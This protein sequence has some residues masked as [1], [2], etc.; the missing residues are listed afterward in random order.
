MKIKMVSIDEDVEQILRNAKLEGNNLTLQG[1][2]TPQMYKKVMKVLEL[3]GF[4]WS[5]KAKCHIGE[6]DSAEKFSE[7]LGTGK[8]V[9][10]K[11][12]YQFFETP[13]DVAAKLA[14]YACIGAGDRVLE[15]SAGKGALIRAIQNEYPKLGHIFACELN[16][17]MA[18]DLASL[19]AASRI[20]G[21]GDVSVAHGDFLE[22]TDKYDRIVMNPPF[23]SFQ[24]GEHVQHAYKLLLPGGRVVAIMSKGWHTNSTKKPVAFREWFKE[25]EAKGFAEVAEELE[26]GAFSESGTKVATEIV[27]LRKPMAK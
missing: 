23:N 25:L 4:Q 15:P 26:S 6:G 22:H 13:K 18:N 8:V 21:H 14:S 11:Q 10:E 3:I 12:T 27:I 1:Q 17:Q 2:L 19:A 9:N 5:K 24:D 16:P 7:A 20:A